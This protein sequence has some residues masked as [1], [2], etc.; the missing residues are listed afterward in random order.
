LNRLILADHC[1]FGTT[2]RLL[3]AAGYEVICLKE[4]APQDTPDA[5]LVQLAIKRSMVLLTNDKDFCDILSY[6]PASHSGVIVLRIT[7]AT[8]GRVHQV[9][10]RLLADHTPASLM[11]SLAVVSARKYR[12]RI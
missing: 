6:P 8:E 7:A 12:L 3:R 2:V 4:I 1:V 10:L 5:D 11:A 9:L